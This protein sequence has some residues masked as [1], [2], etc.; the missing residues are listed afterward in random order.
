MMAVKLTLGAFVV[1]CTFS[2]LDTKS[3]PSQDDELEGMYKSL[4]KTTTNPKF[5][6]QNV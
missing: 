6:P 5:Q 4:K 3:V 1:L 2:F